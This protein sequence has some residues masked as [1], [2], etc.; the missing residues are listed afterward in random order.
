MATTGPQR[1]PGAQG[2]PRAM[3]EDISC[4]D[5]GGSWQEQPEELSLEK[6]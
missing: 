2:G 1:D 4:R 6:G 3:Q 5:C